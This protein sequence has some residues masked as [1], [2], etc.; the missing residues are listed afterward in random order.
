MHIV[1]EIPLYEFVDYQNN[2]LVLLRNANKSSSCCSID[3]YAN[4]AINLNNL[5]IKD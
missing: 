3:V 5:P 4:K 2:F 1:T